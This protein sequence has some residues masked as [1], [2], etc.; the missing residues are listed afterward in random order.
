MLMRSFGVDP[1]AMMDQ[2][3]QFGN[4]VGDQLRLLHTK[5]DSLAAGQAAIL[6]KLEALGT[7][8]QTQATVATGD[9]DGDN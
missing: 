5:L 4:E 6:A 2:V 3:T 8:D 7:H 1:K 9:N